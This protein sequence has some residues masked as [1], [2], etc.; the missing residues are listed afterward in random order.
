[1]YRG[2]YP[3]EP[4]ERPQTGPA[5]G[6]LLRPAGNWWCPGQR[7][8]DAARIAGIPHKSVLRRVECLLTA[9]QTTVACS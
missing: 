8:A 4:L 9:R 2:R 6:L 3:A 7:V 5:A 1:M